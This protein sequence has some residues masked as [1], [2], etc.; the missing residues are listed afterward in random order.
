MANVKMD[1]RTGLMELDPRIMMECQ[2]CAHWSG[3]KQTYAPGWEPRIV[4]KCMNEESEYHGD[5]M[6]DTDTCDEHEMI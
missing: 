4:G 2:T 3:P 6:N 5:T 1:P